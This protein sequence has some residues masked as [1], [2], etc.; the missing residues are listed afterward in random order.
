MTPTHW[1]PKRDQSVRE[2]LAL[3][4]EESVDL[5]TDE[6]IHAWACQGAPLCLHDDPSPEAMH[7]CALCEHFT[8]DCH[9]AV[10]LMGAGHA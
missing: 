6:V 3:A 1:H 9:G 5:P 8:V 7:T 4:V 10:R 2:M